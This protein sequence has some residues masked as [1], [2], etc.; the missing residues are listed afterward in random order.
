MDRVIDTSE[1]KTAR[2]EALTGDDGDGDGAVA[3]GDE[4]GGF[5]WGLSL[6]GPGGE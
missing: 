1:R 6:G 2:M 3:V 5:Y 4:R